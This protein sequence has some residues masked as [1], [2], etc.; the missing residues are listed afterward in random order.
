MPVNAG[1]EYVRAEQKYQNAISKEEK[2]A[3]LAEMLRTVPKHKGTENLRKEITSK[4]AK[5]KRELEKEKT[6][7]AKKGSGATL[8]VKKE[9]AAQV[10]IVGMPNTGKSSLLKSLTNADTEIAAY[11]FT[12]KKPVAG[13][14]N[15]KG[16]LIQIV[17]MPAVIEGSSRGKAN[18]MQVLSSIRNA[19]ALIILFT[20]EEEKKVVLKELETTGIKVNKEKPKIIIKTGDFRGISLSGTSHLKSKPDE[21]ISTLKAFGIHNASV[22][23][24][25]NASVQSLVEA[26]NEKLSYKKALFLNAFKTRFGEELKK[27]IFELAGKVIVYTKKPGQEPDYDEPLVLDKGSTAQDCARKLHKDLAKKLRF[28]RVWGS[29]RFSGQMVSKDYQLKNEDIIEINI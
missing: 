2:L 3:A 4:I 20:T 16:A 23:F 26:L 13:M 15:Y 24:L 5:L 6:A 9:G 19:D 11:P 8:N 14:M 22:Q 17:D 10:A 7:P 21:I 1:F 27:Q 25:E 12:T 29:T 18:G 28:A